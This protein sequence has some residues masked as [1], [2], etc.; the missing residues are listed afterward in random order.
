MAAFAAPTP[1]RHQQ[2]LGQRRQLRLGQRHQLAQPIPLT[3]WPVELASLAAGWAAERSSRRRATWKPT[4]PRG[5]PFLVTTAWQ[6]VP[7]PMQRP[8]EPQAVQALRPPAR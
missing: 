1:R 4:D 8:A 6:R 5:H 2:P 7:E 3:H